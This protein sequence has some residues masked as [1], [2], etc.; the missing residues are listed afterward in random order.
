MV[1]ICLGSLH[2]AGGL[3]I[4]IVVVTLKNLFLYSVLIYSQI[5]ALWSA[6]WSRHIFVMGSSLIMNFLTGFLL[7]F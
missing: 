6:L 3:L 1:T 4:E 7:C 2:L 5:P